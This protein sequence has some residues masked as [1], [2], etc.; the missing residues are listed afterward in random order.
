MTALEKELV[1]RFGE[2]NVQ[3]I[4][5]S[6]QEVPLLHV[7]IPIKNPVSVLMTNGLSNYSMPVPEKW[8]GRECNEIFFCLPSY[9]DLDDRENPN[10]NWVFPWI[11]RLTHYVQEKKTWFGP[12]HTLPC[13]K[14]FQALSS[15]MKSNHL[16]LT[17]PL[18]LSHELVPIRMEN[19]TIYFLAIVPIFEDEM[20]YKQGKGTF[21]LLTKLQGHGITEKLDDFRKTSLKSKWRFRV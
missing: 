15:T 17:D 8:K 21:K 1:D 19:R 10:M 2:N 13:G 11:Q 5:T 6:E 12:G 20:D 3:A 7:K 18:L 14:P 9:W 16:L 4:L